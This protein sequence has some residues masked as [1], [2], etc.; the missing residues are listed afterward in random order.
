MYITTHDAAR[1]LG[2]TGEWV[3][4]L[5]K[6]GHLTVAFTRPSGGR[7]GR[8]HLFNLTDV[9]ILKTEREAAKASKATKADGDAASKAKA[10]A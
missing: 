4:Q 10:K 3:R 7:Y 8:T 5:V 6:E 9:L 1:L 2:C